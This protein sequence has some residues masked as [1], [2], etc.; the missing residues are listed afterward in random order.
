MA[1]AYRTRLSFLREPG[2][3]STAW[4][5]FRWRRWRIAPANG[6]TGRFAT[7]LREESHRESDARIISAYLYDSM[8][9]SEIFGEWRITISKTTAFRT[10]SPLLA[11]STR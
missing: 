9:T 8:V 11:Q 3:P 6:L 4:L 1:V 10:I 5:Q 7:A 2:I